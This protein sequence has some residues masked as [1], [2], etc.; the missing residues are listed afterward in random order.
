MS[1]DS[2]NRSLIDGLMEGDRNAAFV[3][4]D[5]Y[6]PRINR[7]V[8]RLLGADRDH[9][10]IVQQVYL[11]VFSSLPKL[12]D[13]LA[14]DAFVDSIAIRTVR[15]EIRRRTYKRLLFGSIEDGAVDDM[16]DRSS[17][18]KEAHIR[19]FYIVLNDLSADERVVFVLR[20][21]EGLSM[22]EIA[23][24]GGY[25]LATTKRRLRKG[26]AKFKERA[27]K[28]TLLL[29]MLEELGHDV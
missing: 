17:P 12:K 7:W 4:C 24:C 22:P 8:W 6:A 13:V 11:G 10:E 21:L 9:D 26:T 5:K 27:L 28:E 15:K 18:L 14:L 1:S 3:F 19:G 20:H 16:R 29:T 2:D 25:S 23:R